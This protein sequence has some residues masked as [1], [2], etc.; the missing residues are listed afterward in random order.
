MAAARRRRPWPFTRS[1]FPAWLNELE[2]GGSPFASVAAKGDGPGGW[3][4]YVAIP[5]LD[6]A[7]AKDLKAYP[8]VARWFDALSARPSWRA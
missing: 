1:C 5:N 3:V 6:A 4:P 7:M 2:R 8:N